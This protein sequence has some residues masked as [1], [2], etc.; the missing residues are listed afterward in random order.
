VVRQYNENTKEEDKRCEIRLTSSLDVV[1]FLIMQGDAFRG[2]DESSTSHNK[3][4]FKELVDRYKGKIEIVK[5]AYEKGKRIVRRCLLIYRR[6]L[7]KLV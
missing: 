5:D 4:T 3:G 1:K 7:K 6:T 2:Q